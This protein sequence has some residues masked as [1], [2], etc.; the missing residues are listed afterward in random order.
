MK[1]L[2][3]LCLAAALAG[4][5]V[6][7]ACCVPNDK[8]GYVPSI[9]KE[10]GLRV[11]ALSN[12]GDTGAWHLWQSVHDETLRSSTP[13]E[14][15][16]FLPSCADENSAEVYNAYSSPVTLDSV[17]LEPHATA[18]V[19]YEENTPYT[20]SFGEENYTLTFLRST[21]EAAV[22]MN[23]ENADGAGTDLFTYI[24][25]M[26]GNSDKSRTAKADCITLDAQGNADKTP[27]KKLK[28][29][30]NTSWGK[31]KKSYNV[32]YEN[33][34]SVAGMKKGKK[35]SL[36]AN[37]QDDSLSRNRILY[38]LSDAVGIPYASDSRCADLYINGYYCGSY[39][40]C[41][42]I[43]V[44]KNSLVNDIEAK[45]YLAPDGTIEGD[46]PF[47]CVVD[48]SADEN[49][50]YCVSTD[51]GLVTIKYPELEPTDPGYEA[52]KSYVAEKYNAFF[53]A[54]AS[55][56]GLSEIG[57]VDSLAKVFLINELGKNW[58]SGV[59]STYF[60]YKPDASGNYKFYGSPVWD[61]DNTLGNAKGVTAELKHL[62]VDDYTEYTGWW[63]MYKGGSENI[64]NRLAQ[65]PEITAAAKTIWF[66]KF[67][68]SL[69]HFGGE[70]SDTADSELYTAD[71]YFSI[72]KGS[73]EMNYKS[74]WRL[75]TGSWIADH[76]T[77]TKAHFDSASKQMVTDSSP[78]AYAADF[79]GSFNYCRDWLI[80]R[81]AWI[82]QEYSAE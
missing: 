70:G 18:D 73:A 3:S 41:E 5:A 2:A 46:L 53:A 17:T 72:A 61:Y 40:M 76:S 33:A 78:T 25:D 23:N 4:C 35:Y 29:R 11:H 12:S 52:V 75:N 7:S 45:D 1:K 37:Y 66:D 80:S 16:F 55:G 47:L 64:M 30:G 74:G 26:E 6:L 15:Y 9:G 65:N 38:D 48:P 14:K 31:S 34:L 24:N 19:P 43:A 39:Q 54:A 36:V 42:K 81:A 59:S 62:G 51:G 57:D 27:V 77:L 50:D 67:V 69:A 10:E 22:F 60:V 32:T 63:C 28:G 56:S 58:D 20:V 82:S 68:P 44:G 8:L 71:R 13:S 49:A 79:E 21:A